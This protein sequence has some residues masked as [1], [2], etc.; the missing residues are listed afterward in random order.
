MLLS[1]SGH[2]FTFGNG[3]NG[4]LG[5]GEDVTF[6]A[7]PAEVLHETFYNP[8]ASI[9]AGECFSAAVTAKGELYMWGKNMN[10]IL[11]DELLPET[12]W[13]PRHIDTQGRPLSKVA[14][15]SWH[16][17][18]LT[19]MPVW[20][21]VQ[22]S[23]ATQTDTESESVTECSTPDPSFNDSH[24]KSSISTHVLESDQETSQEREIAIEKEA[25]PEPLSVPLISRQQSLEQASVLSEKNHEQNRASSQSSQCSSCLRSQNPICKVAASPVKPNANRMTF[26]QRGRGPQLPAMKL[27][28]HNIVLNMESVMTSSNTMTSPGV[29]TSSR[30]AMTSPG[31]IPGQADRKFHVKKYAGFRVSHRPPA[32]QKIGLVMHGKQVETSLQNASGSTSLPSMSHTP[33]IEPEDKRPSTMSSGEIRQPIG[34]LGSSPEMWSKDLSLTVGQVSRTHH[35]VQ[36]R[37]RNSKPIGSG[38][39]QRKEKLS[40]QSTVGREKQKGTVHTRFLGQGWTLP[41]YGKS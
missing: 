13:T 16:V 17:M 31:L 34:H 7:S 11:S 28:T 41:S 9:S 2:V 26:R 30:R 24:F 23:D 37:G 4:Q 5:H 10:K 40:V 38:L 8:V 33:C 6:L 1:G 21:A 22:D 32:K 25:V 39:G 18:A 35:R 19:G 27:M 29:M 3:I 36:N 20:E 12:I 14:C 15:G